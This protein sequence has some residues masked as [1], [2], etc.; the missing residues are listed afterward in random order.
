MRRSWALCAL[1][2]LCVTSGAWGASST[3][4]SSVL[5]GNEQLQSASDNNP[6]GMAQAFAYT[7]TASG[8]TS[9]IDLYV[10]TG[11]TATKVLVGVY[12]DSSGKPGS[13]LASGSIT[14]PKAGAWNDATIGRTTI[15]QG[16]AYWIALLPTGGQLNY[17]DAAGQSGAA[18]SYVESN[19]ELTALPTSYTSGHKWNA[20]PASIYVNGGTTPPSNT[21][22]PVVSGTAQQGSTLST[23][24]GSWT[25]SP[26]SYAY[27]WQRCDSTGSNCSTI[28][29]ATSGSY[30]LTSSDVGHTL[31]SAVTA[32]NPGG[33]TSAT[34]NQTGSV[35]APSSVL[36]GNEQLQSA[37]DNNPAGMAQAF[38][39]T[40]TASGTT[41][42]IDLY[43]N[44]GT[45]ATKVLVGVYSDSSG[46]PGSLLASGSI[47]SPK[48]GAWNDATIGQTTITQ[49]TAYWIA[50]LP[51]GGQLNYLDA[52]GQSGAAA[53]YVESNSEL[54][55]LPTSYTSGHKWNASPASIYVNGGTTPP[56]NTGVPV[57]SGTAQQGSTLST[58]NGSWTGSPTSYAYQWQD[59]NSAG[60]SCANISGAV[61][62]SYVL[63]SRDV[64]STVRAVVDACNTTTNCGYADSAASNMVVASGGSG[65]S[66]PTNGSVPAVVDSTLLNNYEAAD[67]VQASV[68][69]WNNCS[70]GSACTY[71]YQFQRCTGIS[72]TAG[73]GCSNIGAPQCSATAATTC[74]YTL[75]SG[76]VGDYIVASVTASNGS[77]NS[78][79]AASQALGAVVASRI[80][81]PCTNTTALTNLLTGP[82]LCGWPDTTNVGYANAPGYPGSLTVASS[83]SSTC[84]TTP[85]SNHTY[86]FCQW[87]GLSLPANLTNV[88][89]YGDGF[90]RTA[91]QNANVAGGSGDN[92]ITFDYDTF[93]PPITYPGEGACTSASNCSLVTC[94]QSYQYGIYNENGAMKG[95]TVENSWF[96]GFGNAIDTSG[97]T[98]ASPQIFKYN[99]FSDAVTDSSCGYHTDGIGMLNTA[100][101]SYATVDHNAFSFI[102]NTNEI[103]WQN[104]SYDHIT[105]TNNFMDGDNAMYAGAR[106][107]SGCTA[108]TFIATTGNTFDAF[109]EHGAGDYPTDLAGG[110][111]T[112]T[113]STWNHNYWMVPPGSSSTSAAGTSPSAPG[114]HNGEFVIPNDHSNGFPNDCGWVSHTDYPN[115]TTDC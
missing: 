4:A 47:T 70:G 85:Q 105:N 79:P 16:T 101:E 95:Y 48:A 45:T 80:N 82:H 84:P 23:S 83:G 112:A 24:N 58:S 12:S 100:T 90:L 2:L 28:S 71:I 25:G 49:G 86:S 26:T 98:Q 41:S 32:T 99:F 104:G 31:R 38:A 111:A 76:D 33:S 52:A 46:K 67:V 81:Q 8:T 30:N 103:A 57:V 91:P 51:T 22:V 102:G 13:L 55:A 43:V 106:C 88:T 63:A 92:N 35:A 115:T 78:S 114:T 19:S 10:N 64:G 34:S 40:A 5:V 11:T 21:G 108:A 44:T 62:S 7:A 69:S 36:V 27:Q 29:G 89:F 94:S 97:S 39:Y 68:G 42:D 87:N 20:S 75:A 113:G 14:S 9:D 17:L 54:T 50:L 37:S 93:A 3:A 15:T 109:L 61:S 66:A 73:T 96:W 56:S 60:A 18:A 74:S 72:G 107:T 77:G 6:A 65:G 1:M 53:S 110:Y 59:C